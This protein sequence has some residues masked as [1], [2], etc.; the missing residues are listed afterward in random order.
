MNQKVLMLLGLV[1]LGLG[2]LVM[3]FAPQPAGAGIT[4]GV[5]AITLTM[6]G[7][8]SKRIA[9]T[10]P[11]FNK[12]LGI[13]SVAAL[14]IQFVVFSGALLRVLAS[15]TKTVPNVH[16]M[17]VLGAILGAAGALFFLLFALKGVVEFDN[18]DGTPQR[19]RSQ[20]RAPVQPQ[21]TPP[22]QGQP[23]Q[24]Q[25]AQPQAQ[26][27]AQPFQGQPFQGQPFQGQPGQPQAPFQPQ[28]PTHR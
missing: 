27:Q 8:V 10:T 22:L 23:F 15:A 20:P 25:P 24:G 16:L 7:L 17:F 5:V 2:I 19:Q 3:P 26:P 18:L 28:D 9:A 14:G 1:L 11:E 21:P 12:P 4:Y 13:V 6:L